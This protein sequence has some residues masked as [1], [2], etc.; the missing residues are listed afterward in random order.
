MRQVLIYLFQALCVRL[1]RSQQGVAPRSCL[2]ARPVKPRSRPPP[3]AR[4]PPVMGPNGRMT[5]GHP[6]GRFYPGD[7]RPRS[8]A[9]PGYA[10]PPP[11]RPYPQSR[12]GSPV[13]FPMPGPMGPSIRP[14]PRSMSPGF[15]AQPAPRSM[16][17]GPY[18]PPGMQRQP[19]MPVN[20]RQRSNSAGNMSPPN[21]GAVPPKS[22]SPLASTEPP[23]PAPSAELPAI[24]SSSPSSPGS[25][26]NR[27]PLPSQNF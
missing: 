9:G 3:G 11:P 7:A 25:Q 18:G 26:V 19:V 2:S 20:Q 17:P 23:A 12:S 8:P 16:S 10:G 27:K 22:S 5:S 1:D 4:G 14:V 13:Q 24:P 6:S 15:G 21:V